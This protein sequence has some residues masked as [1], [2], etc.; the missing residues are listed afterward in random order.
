MVDERGPDI[1]LGFASIVVAVVVVDS[2]DLRQ[3]G[4]RVVSCRSFVADVVVA[5]GFSGRCVLSLLLL[6]SSVFPSLAVSVAPPVVP[7]GVVTATG[8][9][10]FSLLGA[11]AAADLNEPQASVVPVLAVV[12]VIVGLDPHSLPSAVATVTSP[13]PFL[14]SPLRD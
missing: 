7:P 13:A 12:I 1:G 14:S 3:I 10:T 2:L 5:F 11:R 9:T 4:R 8:L 6:E